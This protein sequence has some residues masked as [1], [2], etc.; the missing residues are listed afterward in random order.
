M[1]V[2]DIDQKMRAK[3]DRKNIINGKTAFQGILN[4]GQKLTRQ[5]KRG[6]RATVLEAVPTASLSL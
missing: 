6:H 4:K 3:K 5:K 1:V 2:S